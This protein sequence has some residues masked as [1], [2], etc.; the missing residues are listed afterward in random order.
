MNFSLQPNV[1]DDLISTQMTPKSSNLTMGGTS[2]ALIPPGMFAATTTAAV[3]EPLHQIEPLTRNQLM[4]AF[5]YLLRTDPEFVNKLHE[6]Y[7]KS[8]SEILS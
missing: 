4:Q 2:L 1:H 5:N 6:A 3:T 8:F 7:V